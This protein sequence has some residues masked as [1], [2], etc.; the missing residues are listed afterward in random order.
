MK[1]ESG[2]LATSIVPTVAWL[3][4]VASV[5]REYGE[6]VALYAR[7]A[8][9]LIDEVEAAHRAFQDADSALGAAES[10]QA[11][12]ENGSDAAAARRATSNVD[13]A[14]SALSGAQ[15][16]LN[17]LWDQ[18]ERA[19]ARWDDAYGAAIAAL[20]NVDGRTLSASPL[21]ASTLAAVDA[22]ANA[23]SPDEV[24]RVWDDLS[25]AQRDALRRTHPE[26]IGN[27]EGIPYLDRFVANRAVYDA[28]VKAGPYGE[29]LDSQLESLKRELN[30][31]DGQLLMFHPLEEPQATAAVMYGVRISDDDGNPIDPLEGITNVNVLVGGM[32]SSLGD[33]KAWGKSARDLDEFAD[34]YGNGV[35]S[36]T[37]AWYGYDSPNLATEHTMGSATEGSATLT[38][39]LLGLDTAVSAAV[40]TSVIGHSYGST[41]AFLAV[42]GAE[43]D[44]GVDRL[45]AVGSAGVPDG[46]HAGWT[47]D[48]PMDYSD[49]EVFASRAPGDIVARYGEH[50]SFGHGTDPET[51][52]G[53]IS[54][55]SDGGEVPALNGGTEYGLGTPGHAAHDGGNAP[56]WGWWEQDNGYL[57]R[58]SESFRNIANVVA[59]GEPLR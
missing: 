5:V 30:S 20:V 52:P 49:I 35:R 23:D 54:F 39:S 19:Y 50:S 4:R 42:G 47:G 44:L 25:E 13:D 1:S 34:A 51:L 11:T 6:A 12:T 27:L 59:N 24:A 15:T 26:F 57:S 58:D 56:A 22:L 9:A 28:T 45:V 21:G 16:T 37:I 29:P 36:A 46:Y 33:L 48:D 55:E 18:W 31:F 32:F 17:D 7:D 3:R 41:T 40:T 2:A 14:Q 38:Q 10:E 43:G 8:N 53:A